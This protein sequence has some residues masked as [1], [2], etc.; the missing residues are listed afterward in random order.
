MKTSE[1]DSSASSALVSF[2]AENIR[3]YRDEV[4]LSLL[5]TRLAEPGAARS[6]SLSGSAKQV[7]VLPAAGVFGANASGKTALLEAM[8][9]LRHIVEFSFR[10]ARAG[11]RIFRRP[12]WLDDESSERPSRFEVELILNGVRWQ[13]GF[14]FD[15]YRVL[16]EYAYHYP[17]GR[18]ARVFHR[19]GASVEFGQPFRS[20]GRALLRPL[21]D[22]VLLASVAGAFGTKGIAQ[23]HEW[24][25]A[26]QSIASSRNRA[27]RADLTAGLAEATESKARVLSLMRYADLGVTDIHREEPPPELLERIKRIEREANETDED[28][29]SDEQF[30][31][32]SKIHLTHSTADGEAQIPPDEESLGTQVW[33][34]LTGPILEALDTGTVLLVDE[35]DASLHPQL[36][37][38]IIL[39]FQ[40]E[41]TN[42]RCAQLIFNSHDTNI[43]GDTEWRAMGRDQVWF[44]EKDEDGKTSLYPLADFGPRK[45]D[46]IERRYLQGRYGATP[47]FNPAEIERAF[48][49][50]DS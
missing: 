16:E 38:K 1:S 31:L 17:R 21:R 50:S 3:S 12:F 27:I 10:R 8:D 47:S 23:I 29:G 42:P 43:L 35:L 7:F 11:S 4:H 13:Y 36:V 22:N 25:E 5:A 44:T 46:A 33:L 40:N 9:D 18:Q 19:E 49:T 34:A 32:P 48:V 28:E 24:F 45:D 14:T 37:Q 20:E 30:N 6:L 39:L 26:N 41:R 2:T 15:D